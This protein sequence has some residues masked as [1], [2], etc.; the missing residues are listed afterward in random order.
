MLLKKLVMSSRG[1]VLL[2]VLGDLEYQLNQ[3]D[4]DAALETMNDM[5]DSHYNGNRKFV[6][7]TTEIF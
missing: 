2:S 4:L 5:C 6:S 7:L 1:D 3:A